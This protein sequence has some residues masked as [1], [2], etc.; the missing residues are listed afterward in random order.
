MHQKWPDKI[1]PI[2]NFVFS[3]NSHFG[4][5]GGSNPPPP[6]VYGYSNTSLG[7]PVP[8]QDDILHRPTKPLCNGWQ[9]PKDAGHPQA[10]MNAATAA[11][12]PEGRRHSGCRAV[13]L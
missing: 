8:L 11:G 2:A 3:Q 6:M 10:G 9:Q 4:L 7:V 13:G 1:F 5:A 12:Q